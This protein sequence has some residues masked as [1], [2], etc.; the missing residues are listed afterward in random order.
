MRGT[1]EQ[2][3]GLTVTERIPFLFVSGL[4]PDVISDNVLSY[5]A[6]KSMLK[7]N[8]C[9]QIKTKKDNYH[10]SYKLAV[11]HS[12]R[13]KYLNAELWPK[14][15]AINHFL[16]IQRRCGG[17]NRILHLPRLGDNRA[18]KGISHQHKIFKI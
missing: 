2:Q 5:L 14:G 3:T 10:S 4:G 1:C 6:N 11:P 8:H 16:S 9:E 12:N 7:G 13:E 17:L 15:V 18:S